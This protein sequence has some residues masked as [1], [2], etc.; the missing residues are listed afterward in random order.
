MYHYFCNYLCDLLSLEHQHKSSLTRSQHKPINQPLP[1]RVKTK[2]K[3]E[4]NPK[5][6]KGDL[7]WSKLGGKNEKAEKYS[8]N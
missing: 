1:P 7:K 3:K 8:T 6:G 4:Y 5:S 2:R